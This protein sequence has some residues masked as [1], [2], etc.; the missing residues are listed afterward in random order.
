MTF[1][2]SSQILY[3]VYKIPSDCQE[4]NNLI[5]QSNRLRAPVIIYSYFLPE[6]RLASIASSLEKC[7]GILRTWPGQSCLGSRI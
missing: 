1:F 4:K 2:I 5:K 6:Y 7:L 3:T